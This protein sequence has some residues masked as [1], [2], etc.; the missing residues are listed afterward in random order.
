MADAEMSAPHLQ[1][2]PVGA[3]S[4]A[5]YGG[6]ASPPGGPGG[7]PKRSLQLLSQSRLVSDGSAH[8]FLLC[9][10][11]EAVDMVAVQRQ[12]AATSPKGAEEVVLYHTP[13]QGAPAGGGPPTRR[14]VAVSVPLSLAA[15]SVLAME[16]LK[17]RLL[18]WEAELNASL[19]AID[20]DEGPPPGAPAPHATTQTDG[21]PPL[22]A[23]SSRA[24]GV[25]PSSTGAPSQ[26]MGGGPV[27]QGPP[28]PATQQQS[29]SSQRPTLFNLLE[30][31]A[32]DS[33]TTPD[34][35]NSIR[36][37]VTD[38]LNHDL[39]H[40]K[41]YSFI[42]AVVGHDVLHTIVRKLENEPGR[43][44][45]PDA[46]GLARIE[47]A[48]G[49]GVLSSGACEA[50]SSGSGLTSR[51]AI[52]RVIRRNLDSRRMPPQ[53]TKDVF[54]K[55][56]WLPVRRPLTP[57]PVF[58]HTLI[59]FSNKAIF[60]GGSNGRGE[61]VSFRSA[62]V[63]N[64]NFF[65]SRIFVFCGEHPSERDGHSTNGLTLQH[66]PGV[67]LFGGLSDNQF[68]NDVYVLE[69]DFKR[70]VRK[71]PAGQPPAPRDQHAASVFPA[72]TE[73]GNWRDS[74]ADNL[75]E[76]LFIFGG[77]T[78]NPRV[79]F[80]CLNDMWALHLPSNTWKQVDVGGVRPPP[81]YGFSMIWSEDLHLSL[82]GGETHGASGKVSCKERVLLEDFWHFKIKD[83]VN[84]AHSGP[85]VVGEWQQEEYEGKIG[86][87]SHYAAIFITQRY[88][89]P[90]VGV[91]GK[92]T[93]PRTIE[94]LMLIT[95]GV[96]TVTEGDRT[97]ATETDQISVY[98]FSKKQWYTVKPRYPADYVGEPFGARQRHV[99]CFFETH[100]PLARPSRPP[101]PCLFV[102]GG[103]RRH[104]VLGDAWVLSLTGDDPYKGLMPQG[105]PSAVACPV[106]GGESLHAHLMSHGVNTMRLMPSWYQRDTHTPGIL[107]ALCSQ[108]RWLLGAIAQLVDNAMHPSVGCRNVW[109]KFE[110]TPDRDPMLS[111]QDDG[112]GLDYP[113]MNKLLRL[114]G[115]FEPGERRR[116]GYEYG[117]GFKMAYG[118]IASS[119]AIMS[120]TQGTIGIGMLSLEL[121][122][123]CDAREI[124][125]PM[126]MWRLPNK[127]LINR[128]PN[129]MADH[130]HHQRLL[131]TYGVL[132]LG[133][134]TEQSLRGSGR[135]RGSACR[136][137]L[138]RRGERGFLGGVAVERFVLRHPSLLSRVRLHV[139][140]TP[141]TTPSLL[142]DQI[143]VLGTMPGSRIVFW[144]LRDDLDALVLDPRDCMLYLSSA[145]SD[146]RP[147][148]CGKGEEGRPSLAGEAEGSTD[149]KPGGSLV[150]SC[151]SPAASSVEPMNLEASQQGLSNG[152][153]SEESVGAASEEKLQQ[154]VRDPCRPRID[155][156]ATAP[157]TM[158]PEMLDAEERGCGES[159]MKV[160]QPAAADAGGVVGSSGVED[161][162]EPRELEINTGI[163][164][165]L[166]PYFPLWTTAR[167]APDYCLA[168]YLFWL[169]LHAPATTHVQG[170]PLAPQPASYGSQQPAKPREVKGPPAPAEQADEIPGEVPPAREQQETSDTNNADATGSGWLLSSTSRPQAALAE[171]RST[172]GELMTDGSPVAPS[173]YIFLKQR[174]YC[175]AEL[176]YLF[177]PADHDAGCFALMGFLN[178]PMDNAY[179]PRVCEAGVL[180]YFKQRLIRKLECTFPDAP[181]YIDAARLPPSER[182]FGLDGE[183]PQICR[184]A[185]T[186]VI[187][188]PEWMLP[189]LNKQEFLHENN[190]P[191]MKFKA[192]C[193]K[194]MQDYLSRCRNPQ[195]LSAW[196]EQRSKRL[197]DY[198]EQQRRSRPKR[199]LNED[200]TDEEQ[201]RRSPTPPLT[202]SS[203]GAP[204]WTGQRG[205]NTGGADSCSQAAKL[206]LQEPSAAAESSAYANE[207]EAAADDHRGGAQLKKHE[208]GPEDMA[209][210]G[211]EAPAAPEGAPVVG[212]TE[213]EER[214]SKTES[215]DIAEAAISSKSEEPW[216]QDS[217][218]PPD[219][220][221]E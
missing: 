179:Q 133:F 118:R 11:S 63:I 114:Y 166:P 38:F 39:P 165:A 172:D 206:Q 98:F 65:S 200:L 117:C 76:F 159:I 138:L 167:H 29:A 100:N 141:F 107:W 40:S 162:R 68:C 204:I 116:K 66:S 217:V 54:E 58:G 183:P 57:V 44:G 103:F 208:L 173:L 111:V 81:R 128:D 21:V 85:L 64:L 41:V 209:Q 181:K 47:K 220:P 104:Q 112:Q 129:N 50:V 78:G 170:I 122:G 99:A 123:H 196:L 28:P 184:Y 48:F 7:M 127:E 86:P 88:Q 10:P 216:A 110:E 80:H 90:K 108:Q 134:G 73:T 218:P 82:F 136:S 198:Q 23:P 20:E 89:E 193:M 102:H 94:R 121:M 145:P 87:R 199:R 202:H 150:F 174:L 67:I 113:A 169:H 180:L 46:G 160:E 84:E 18:T 151:T 215:G 157:P 6:A 213:S 83:I 34:Q 37:I 60:F 105:G 97:R 92:V 156:A 161:T 17:K 2:Q 205:S 139:R 59:S 195:A 171:K 132:G 51:D 212:F 194:L 55:V 203:S 221:V 126:C 163:Q 74:S 192:R 69:L 119:C 15:S 9:A 210:D 77:R 95:S 175:A 142:A 91:D 33:V 27:V 187:N 143:N 49:S 146:V 211:M 182:I 70:W 35:R 1:D 62:C 188:V 197:S 22:G 130:R 144:D 186:A 140:Y 4:S 120:R 5:A 152:L 147:V 52:L 45:V 109:I 25:A 75:S 207:A 214:G 32:S 93:Q 19:T 36:G 124:A 42:G 71:H 106:A 219:T 53:S 131:M 185:F 177:T 168:T 190:K 13:C 176:S 178:D 148:S 153:V 155:E 61:G 14:V 191:Y 158:G 137:R 43:L 154:A 115:S 101:V 164:K 56:R 31:L 135:P 79:S 72:K 26:A 30:A 125:A 12:C 96:T 149:A 189:S 8:H 24:Q 16:L 3:P 201:P